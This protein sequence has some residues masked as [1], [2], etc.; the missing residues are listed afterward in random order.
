KVKVLYDTQTPVCPV[1]QCVLRPG[2]LQEHMEQELSKI[3]QLQISVKAPIAVN[4]LSQYLNLNFT[5][6]QTL[7]LHIKREGSSPTSPLRLAD[8]VHS[9]RYQTFLRVRANRHTRLNVDDLCWCRCY[10]KSAP[11]RPHSA[12]AHL[13]CTQAVRIGKLKRRKEDGQEFKEN[14]CYFAN[15]MNKMIKSPLCALLGSVLVSTSTKD[16]RDSDADLDVDG[17]D[18]LE[19]GRAQYTETDVI[20]CSG[21]SSKEI[22][23]TNGMAADSRLNQDFPQWSNEGSPSTSSGDKA[24]GSSGSPPKTCK[25]SELETIT[26]DSSLMTLDALKARIRELEKQLSKGDRF[27]CLICM[28]TYTT[29]LTSIQC[30]HVHCE[31][32]WLRTL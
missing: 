10:V 3:A 18:T 22:T 9:D 32:C 6:F 26:A 1:C 16:C 23:S 24:D 13:D 12:G 4:T 5:L 21:E 29:P 8:D 27:K 17:D 7:G 15:F 20:P 14:M 2:E 19:Y 28:D 30:W 25:N 11:M 31:E